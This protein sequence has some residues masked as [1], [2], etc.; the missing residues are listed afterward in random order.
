MV[1]LNMKDKT[2]E[3]FPKEMQEIR[4]ISDIVHKE[5]GIDKHKHLYSRDE[6]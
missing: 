2:N 4:K 3:E 5:F 1:D 6:N